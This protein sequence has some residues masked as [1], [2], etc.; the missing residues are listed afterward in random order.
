LDIGRDGMTWP[1]EIEFAVDMSSEPMRFAFLQIRPNIWDEEQEAVSMT[2]ADLKRAICLSPRAMGNGRIRGVQDVIYV[3]P[4]A[5]DS[6]HTRQIATDI[7]RMN[8]ELARADRTC[9]LIGPGRWGSADRWL[10]I[11]VTWEQIST[12]RVIVETTLENFRITPS[13]G[14]H[15]F[16][17]LISLRVGYFTVDTLG[18]G[19][20]TIDWD[21]LAAQEACDETAFVRHVRLY[22]PLDIR[23]DG[24]SQ[25]G[26]I[27]KPQAT[28]A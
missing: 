2:Q 20:D 21:W 1:V 22:Q 17:N 7:S 23:M 13:Q 26:A 9:V 24:R 5:F 8:D 28:S 16:Q 19:E 14:T 15:F 27:L 11:P 3:K 6:A 25:R 12:A 18:D 10:G 4:D